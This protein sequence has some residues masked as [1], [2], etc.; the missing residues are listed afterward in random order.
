MVKIEKLTVP[1]SE[2]PDM[3]WGSDAI[4]EV[5]S[6]LDLP[7]ISLTP[8][9][10]YR[11]VHDSLVNYLGN[12]NPEMILCLHEESAVAVAQGYAK[13]TG[14]PMAVALH[15]N[16]GLMHATMAIFNAYCDRMPMV[17]LGATGPLDAIERRPWID[18]I[19]TAIDQAALIRNY[20]KWDDQPGSVSAAVEAIVRANQVTRSYPSAPTYICLDAGIQEQRLSEPVKIPDIARHIA[21]ASPSPSPQ[22]VDETW[23]LLKEAKK[24]LILIG[25]VS[26][27]RRS[28]DERVAL[29]ESLGACVL[30]DLKIGA[31]FP[32]KHP[33]QP[34][35]PGARITAAGRSLI[36]QAD[37]ILS[38]DW[39][40]LGGTLQTAD[41]G[42]TQVVI[43]CTNDQALHNGWSKDHYV[44]P[45]V[46][47]AIC[48]D[49]NALVE[50]LLLKAQQGAPI[51]RADWP[52]T[53]E[54]EGSTSS[55]HDSDQLQMSEL[56]AAMQI[57]FTGRKITWTGLPLG[58]SN[59]ELNFGDP[60]DYLGRD[61][62]G[63]LGAG[64]GIAVGAALALAGTGRI[65]V[66]VIGDGDYLMSSSAL[67]T[68]AHHK[69]PLL[70]VVANNRAYY[71]DEVHQQRV[72]ITR[73][74]PVEN[75]W[76][77][78][79]LRDPDPDLATIAKGHGLKGFG[80]VRSTVELEKALAEALAEIDAGNAA[81]IDSWVSP[82][83][84]QGAPAEM[85]NQGRG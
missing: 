15:S 44:L 39:V 11:G 51:P 52:P 14:K 43:S 82:R 18:W 55:P 66:A 84:Y 47:L 60:L 42:D 78:Q 59:E 6:R 36:H 77:G 67:W 4:A 46:D 75:R 8:G 69:L 79:H 30:T 1:V 16:V 65:P 71:N 53:L 62:G 41:S 27:S 45:K 2:R 17:I 49:P 48:A 21:P 25:R 32:T 63:G 5:L 72:A 61:G 40:D 7:F 80:P 74:R 3:E 34:A 9:A 24:P 73:G 13:V 64:P 28:W 56:A 76:V 23:R 33:L 29:A 20:I 70:V 83:G 10:S 38:L 58:W 68:A 22:A 26:R 50:E 31:V 35:W 85:S 12:S 37:V 81:L 54:K 19:H 57:A